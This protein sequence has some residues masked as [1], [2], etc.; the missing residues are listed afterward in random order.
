MIKRKIINDP[1]YGFITIPDGIIFKLI[2]HPYF[3]RLRRI[4]QLGITSLVYPGAIHTRFHHALGAMHL[5]TNAIETLRSKGVAITDEETE[6]AQIAILLHDIGHGPFS[7]ILEHSIVSGISHEDISTLFMERLNKEFKGKL[8][9]AIKIFRNQYSKKF[10]HQLVSSQLDVDRLDYL[11]RDTFFTGV[12]EGV[13]GYDRIIKMLTVA[14]GNLVVEAKGIYSIEKF[15]IAR[16]L[17]YWQVYLH[18]TVLSGMELLVNI[19]KRVK[20]L[21]DEDA[22]LFVTPALA[23]FLFNKLSKKEFFNHPELLD[24]FALLDDYDIV[25]SIKVWMTHDD[26]IL[27]TLCKWF[28]NRNLYKTV[29]QSKPFSK[30]EIKNLQEEAMDKYKVSAKDVR[31]FVFSDEVTNDVYSTQ[32]VRINIVYPNGKIM[33]FTKASDN[34]NASAINT[35]TRKYFV[36]YPKGLV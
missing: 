3:Q 30:A 14:N 5:M 32:Q 22:G 9:L 7:H 6:S 28:I 35:V 20:E 18:K 36:C 17:M 4:Q 15:I 27:S 33:D 25:C 16:R 2:E 31:Y 8:T 34:L 12:S 13:I 26:P 23:V 19:L 11:T 21:A 29:I 10:L 24:A 1:I